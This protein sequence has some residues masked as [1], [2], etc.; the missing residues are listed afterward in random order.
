[1]VDPTEANPFEL[2]PALLF[3]PADRPDRYQKAAAAADA[4][5]IDLED[6]VAPENRAHAR[7]SLREAMPDP[8]T[9]I[10]RVNPA[11]TEDFV[12]DLECVADTGIRR[13][14]LAKTEQASDLA[15]LGAFEVIAL[16]ET[17]RGIEN[18]SEIAAVSNVVAL[19]WGAEDLIVSLGGRSSRTPGG[20]YRDVAQYARTRVLFAAAAHGAAAIDAVHLDI[21]DRDGLRA[22]AMDAVAVGFSATACIHP[23]QVEAIRAAYAP[24]EVALAWA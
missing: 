3:C 12:L 14:M 21:A 10:V 8:A 2:G 24:T 4:V 11:A 16:C 17:V 9:T 18:A 20:I 19:M 5:I 22:E 23:S 6:A 7:A 13:V 1:M 15:R